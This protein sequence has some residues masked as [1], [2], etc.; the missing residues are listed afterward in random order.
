MSARNFVLIGAIAL[1]G[2]ACAAPAV[3]TPTPTVITRTITLPAPSPEIVEVTPQSCLDAITTA[4]VAFGLIAD[5][6]L[7]MINK[8]DTHREQISHD[9]APVMLKWRADRTDCRANAVTP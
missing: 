2:S 1:I 4:G 6:Y 8:D 3:P 5:D 9:L 7:A